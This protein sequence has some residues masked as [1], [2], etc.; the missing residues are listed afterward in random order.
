MVPSLTK[1]ESFLPQPT[2]Q[3]VQYN[4]LQQCIVACYISR[5]ALKT[6][7]RKFAIHGGAA[8]RCVEKT[9]KQTIF[10]RRL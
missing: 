5:A 1:N 8:R 9:R 3:K 4:W 10:Y 6:D 2:E 7:V